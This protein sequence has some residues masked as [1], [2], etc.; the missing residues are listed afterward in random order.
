VDV[1]TALLVTVFTCLTAPFTSLI[2][3]RELGA[4]P[5][6]LSL[7]TS[8]S[9]AC[10]LLSP[11]WLRLFAG[12]APLACVV[13]SG[14]VARSLF[15]LVPLIAS[16]WPFMGV[17]VA[18][19]CL[20]AMA[21]PAQAAL[22][23]QVYPR[24]ERGRAL[25]TVKTLGS[26]LGILLV[27]V[28]GKLLG[29]LDYRWIF[30]SAAL[31]GMAGSLRQRELPV[32]PRSPA[33]EAGRPRL[34][35]AWA[36]VRQ[37]RAFR[38]LLAGAF[39][40]GLGVWLQMPANV[41]MVADVLQASTAQVGLFAACGAAAGLV[42]NAW[43]GRLADCRGSLVALRA[44]YAVG[45]SSA[46]VY[47]L[48]GS[49]WALA[50]TAVL[51]AGMHAGLDLVWVLAVIDVA[52]PRRV[53][54]YAAVAATLAGV[55]GVLGPLLSAVIIERFGVQAVYLVSGAAMLAGVLLASRRVPGRPGEPAGARVRSAVA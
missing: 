35:E 25:G 3:R 20:S 52:G 29:W 9:A 6:Q 4:T 39:V 40:F 49:P 2:L 41:L 50:A 18:G 45:A 7:M 27:L 15:M 12:I 44:V 13:W 46:L 8:A 47:Y 19:N 10:L 11:A 34:R 26:L 21:G 53:A 5:F 24:A 28:S 31:L 43:W 37:D 54:P 55:R 30:P 17:I 16:P 38:S 42:A 36:A 51:D 1:S 33:D 23:E 32:P 48:A 14:F 22:V